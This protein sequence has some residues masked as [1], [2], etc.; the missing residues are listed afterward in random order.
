MGIGQMVFRQDH[1]VLHLGHHLHV[2][3]AIDVLTCGGQAGIIADGGQHHG[4]RRDGAFYTIHAKRQAQ[5]S[6]ELF[7]HR[8]FRPV[9]E[10][11][12]RTLNAQTGDFTLLLV[13]TGYL[14]G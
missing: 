10:Q 7:H 3:P 1:N 12:Q 4:V 8:A 5:A 11:Q 6:R 14:C 2:D 9:L 13:Y